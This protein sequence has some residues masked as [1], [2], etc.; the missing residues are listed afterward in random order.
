MLSEELKSIV[1]GDVITDSEALRHASRD[2]SLFE[3]TPQVIVAPKDTNDISALVKFVSENTHSEKHLSL[4]ARS[5][6]AC[7]SGGP[8]S[9]SIILDMKPYF[10]KILDVNENNA[11]VQPGTY[12]RDFEKETLRHDRIMP[13]YPASRDIC[14]VGGM[15]ANNAGGEKTLSYGKTQDYVLEL[16]T[17][18]ANGKEYSFKP[19]SKADLNIKMKLQNFE[20]E[21]YRKIFNLIESNKE[22]IMNAKPNVSKNSAGYYLWDV[23]DGKTFDLTKLLVGSQGT[24]GIITE[25]KFRLIQPKKASKMLVIFLKKEDIPKLGEIATKI[26]EFKP[27][28]FESYDKNTFKLALKFFPSLIKALRPKHVFK[29]IMHFLPEFWMLLT[30]GL[31]EMVLMAEFTS[32]SQE[33]LDKNASSA[34]KAVKDLDLKTHITKS[35]E[36]EEEFWVIRRK[37]FE[38]LRNK[39]KGKQTAPFIDDIIVRPKYLPEFLPKLSAI[40]QKYEDKLIY[41]VAGHIGDGNLHI[42]PLMDLTDPTVRA[43]IPKLSDEV[44]ALVKE[45]KGSITAEHN[46]GIIRTPYLQ[47]MYGEDVYNLFKEVKNIFDPKNIFNPG[48]K[49]GGT[50]AFALAHMK[51]DNQ[52]DL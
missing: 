40:I 23:Y 8:L 22:L 29:M 3:L 34:E 6:G 38:L 21:L 9:D 24:L 35:E 18:L 5:G 16:K 7:M 13:S 12:Y 51:K 36:E 43:V 42:I 28:T 14:T 46:D 49:V 15:V 25:I 27:E 30:G 44:Y 50:K 47:D 26:L 32:D 41:T 48:K 39:I 11:T 2:A 20:G 4:T 1:Q 52:H 31:P 33:E 10:N 19:L 17:V 37:S 45:Y